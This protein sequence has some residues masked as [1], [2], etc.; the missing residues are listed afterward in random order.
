MKSNTAK[1]IRKKLERGFFI[2]PVY[3]FG[4]ISQHENETSSQKLVDYEIL[5]QHFLT[6]KTLNQKPICF[7]SN[8]VI[9]ADTTR[10]EICVDATRHREPMRN[11]VGCTDSRSRKSLDSSFKFS[12]LT[13]YTSSYP[14]FN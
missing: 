8:C 7:S 9:T 6:K 3:G 10:Y 13:R 11:F 5:K 14:L 12:Y 2:P 1:V 4:N